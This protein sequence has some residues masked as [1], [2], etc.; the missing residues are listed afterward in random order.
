MSRHDKRKLLAKFRASGASKGALAVARKAGKP[1]TAREIKIEREI[2]AQLCLSDMTFFHGG[3]S[4]MKAGDV[5][6]PSADTGNLVNGASPHS[7][8]FVTNSLS[9]AQW[10]A[11]QC[12][13]GAVYR[14]QPCGQIGVDIAST[15]LLMA[16]CDCRD[17][18]AAAALVSQFTCRSA[19]VLEGVIVAP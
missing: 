17:L 6:R 12:E 2:L 16:D 3:K 4:G 15:R 14:V 11:E 1:P 5:L 13:G 19:R 7:F 8:V 18:A 10:Y 9:Q